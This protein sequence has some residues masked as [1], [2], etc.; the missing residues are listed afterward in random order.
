[1]LRLGLLYD[2]EQYEDGADVQDD[3]STSTTTVPTVINPIPPDLEGQVGDDGKLV[4]HI[5]MRWRKRH[6]PPTSS[7]PP[8]TSS[9]SS[10]SSTP[11]CTETLCTELCSEC[12]LKPPQVWC[13]ECQNT[14]SPTVTLRFCTECSNELHELKTRQGHRIILP[15]V[16]EPGRIRY[17]PFRRRR[18]VRSSPF[19]TPEEDNND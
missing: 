15:Y 6:R 14:Y 3:D 17:G 18:P 2:S 16:C 9:R 11:P 7:Y 8:S 19:W 12:H 1:M 5:G 13:Q 4:R 10:S